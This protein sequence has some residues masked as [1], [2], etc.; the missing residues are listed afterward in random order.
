MICRKSPRVSRVRDPEQRPVIHLSTG[1]TRYEIYSAELAPFPG[2]RHSLSHLD[3]V[4]RLTRDVHPPPPGQKNC[5]DA[6]CDFIFMGRFYAFFYARALILLLGRGR[7]E[8]DLLPC[9][10]NDLM[11]TQT[12]PMLKYTYAVLIMSVIHT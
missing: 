2:S 1:S 3:T 5:V 9:E 6:P 8:V 12:N 7:G 11:Y 10:L 4:F